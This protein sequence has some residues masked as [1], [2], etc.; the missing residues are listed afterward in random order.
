M[1]YIKQNIIMDGTAGTMGKKLTFRVRKGK[2]VSSVKRGPNTTS[3]T[4]EQLVVQQ[5]FE[6]YSI[7]AQ[8]AITDP[9]KKLMY[10]EAVTGGQTA[11]NAAFQDA[12]RPPK[13][14]DVITDKY[15]GIVGDVIKIIA[16]D[17]VR[18][19]S[20]KVTILSAGGATLEQ[21][22]AVPGAGNSQ[23]NYITTI[24]NPA[25]PGTRI[26]IR[27]TDLPGNKTDEELV[28]A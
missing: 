14:T 15:N 24:A 8:E 5:K 18:V 11:F 19:E 17:V 2:T 16:K 22:D 10:A 20:V 25:L 26:Q 27:A 13:I 7:Y 6:R 28:I 1:A 4:E 23:W 3:P 21:G 12:A 9:V